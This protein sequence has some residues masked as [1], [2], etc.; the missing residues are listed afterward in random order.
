MGNLA[1]T[2]P[3]QELM[4]LIH[5]NEKHTCV[6]TGLERN[7]SISAVNSK[8]RDRGKSS[9]FCTGPSGGGW[10]G[11]LLPGGRAVKHLS[12]VAASTPALAR[13]SNPDHFQLLLSERKPWATARDAPRLGGQST[14]RRGAPA[15]TPAPVSTRTDSGRAAT[16]ATPEGEPRELGMETASPPSDTAGTTSPPLPPQRHTEET[17]DAGPRELSD[18]LMFQLPGLCC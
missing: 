13:P 14:E 5:Q 16:T 1:N 8:G 17:Q 7:H 6:F 12:S 10:G 18:H 11:G 2:P 15:G 4:H 3:S 9:S